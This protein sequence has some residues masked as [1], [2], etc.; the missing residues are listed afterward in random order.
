M[1]V[2]E[3][4]KAGES[5]WVCEGCSE[6]G[7]LLLL[8]LESDLDVLEYLLFLLVFSVFIELLVFGNGLSIEFFKFG[9]AEHCVAF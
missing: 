8:P 3:R 2:G 7:L 6:D 1:G 5:E 4:N 9:G